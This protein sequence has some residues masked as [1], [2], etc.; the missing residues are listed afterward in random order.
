VSTQG[1]EGRDRGRRRRGPTRFARWLIGFALA[2]LLLG[3]A[4]ASATF[5]LMRVRE[6]YPAG[7]ASYVMLQMLDVGENQVGGH[8]LVIYNADG[9]IADNFNMPNNV[10]PN[11]RNNSTILIT[12]PGYAAA[13]PS[14]PTT[15]E[16]DPDLNLS[17]S[18]GAVCWVEGDPPDCVAWGNFTGP[19]P[20]HTPTLEVGNPARPGGVTAGKALRRTIA[21]G[22][23][24][25][26]EAG[27]D[28]DDSATDFS[29][30]TPNPRNNADPITE[31]DCET[32]SVQ[33]DSKPANPTKS[34]T[35]QFVFHSTPSGASFECK[36]D[37]GPFVSCVH[38]DDEPYEYSGLGDGSHTFQVRA[39]NT[40]GTGIS[41]VF[42]WL[43]DTQ[44]PTTTI[45]AGPANPSAGAN[46][47]FAY[48]ASQLSSTFECS[49]AAQGQADSFASCPAGGTTYA[50]LG[51]GSYTFRVRA[52]DKAGNQGQAA[53]YAWVVNNSITGPP[54]TPP[55]TTFPP[56]TIPKPP[57]TTPLHC[58]KGFLKKKVKGQL[59]CVKKKKK[60][61]RK[62]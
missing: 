16:P 53:A 44:A 19:L 9:S 33:L 8:H 3:A 15:D 40:Q 26:L 41:T 37:T 23:A 28:S 21:P 49:L 57:A 52:T 47:T 34:T 60:K 42:S 5:H 29:E 55:A 6:V 24:T 39:I 18:G 36:L 46:V 45:S 59:R 61:K 27:D 20:A 48:A 50:S 38:V 58:K 4:P 62:H 56:L 43:V 12:G 35:A 11:S 7:G 17:G 1:A 54:A 30:Q 32:P 2:G 14:G 22:C 10:S 31:T 13:F 51:D 25:I